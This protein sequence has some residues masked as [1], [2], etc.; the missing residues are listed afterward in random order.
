VSRLARGMR[1]RK[2]VEIEYQKEADAAPSTRLVEPYSLERELPNWYVH[3]WDRTS[4]G[5]RSFRLDRMRSAKVTREKFEPR[6]GFEP[7]RLRD[8]RTAK[9]FYD[10]E[11]ARWAVER[12]GG[13]RGGRALGRRGWRADARRRECHPRAAVQQRRLARERGA[14]AAGRGGPARAGGAA[15]HGRRARQGPREGARRGTPPRPRLGPWHSTSGTRGTGALRSRTRC[16]GRATS[17]SST[18][19]TTC[20]TSSSAGSRRTGVRSTSGSRSRSA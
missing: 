1:E 16:L 14:L 17:I 8:A 19:R 10:E 3:T 2:L 4:D 6:E 7:T 15:A 11:I 13:G 20:R 12:G 5:A 9:L 18:S